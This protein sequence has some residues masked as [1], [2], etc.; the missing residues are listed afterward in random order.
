MLKRWVTLGY[1]Y[2]ALNNS[3][4]YIVK[5]ALVAPAEYYE[6]WFR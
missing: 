4:Q 5:I 1:L 2:P 3:A 6:F